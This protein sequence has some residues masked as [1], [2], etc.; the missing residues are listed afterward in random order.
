MS[1]RQKI[2]SIVPCLAY[3]FFASSPVAWTQARVDNPGRAL[4]KNAGRV[5]KLEEVLRIR[6]DGATA[7]FRSPRELTLGPDKYL[8]FRDYA[9]GPR[10]YRYSPE[11][12]LITKLL[13]TGQGPGEVQIPSGF[14]VMEDRIRVLAWI[15]PKIMDFSL[16][17]R[18]L[19]E[20]RVAEDAHGLWFLAAAEGKIYGIR[21]E[22][23]SSAAFRSSGVFSIP[24]SVYEISPDFRSWKKL[25]EFPVRMV[26]KRANAFRLDPI[27]A[28]IHGST[29]YILHTAEYQVVAFD[30]R[31]GRVKHVITRAYDRVKAGAEKA[32]DPDPETRGIE[33][34]DDPY[35]WDINRIHAAAGK[36]WVFTSV[37]KPDGDDQQ[38]DI[39]DEAGRF[40]DNIMLRFP[41]SGRSHRARWTVLTDD[42]F[43]II[44]EQ[45]EDGL[46][47]IG[48]YRIA[49]AD[50]FPPA[51]APGDVRAARR[52]Q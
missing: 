12:K 27:D 40:V 28:D 20:S 14:L 22:V 32:T 15:P 17:G 18:Y 43:F 1:T 10:L 3:L 23:F 52:G 19:R 26:I 29:L 37:M 39:F 7:I 9:E 4:A 44:P 21:D 38:V 6:D 11:G 31:A 34:P 47:S 41:A 49:D 46:I 33:F 5:V 24:N 30:L 25:Y 50:L 48:K 51:S 16:D 8:Y 45:E 13:K 42:G 35:V 2:L 36:L